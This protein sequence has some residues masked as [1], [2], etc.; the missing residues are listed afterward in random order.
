MWKYYK[1]VVRVT[2]LLPNDLQNS[3]G[4]N[5][6]EDIW[7]KQNTLDLV[8]P[9]IML[10]GQENNNTERSVGKKFQDILPGWKIEV[11]PA[12]T[13]CDSTFGPLEAVRLRCNTGL[14]ILKLIHT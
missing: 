14:M 10:A 5:D 6:G 2:V 13:I 8:L 1:K 7:T 3:P 4:G 9:G 12:D 11:T